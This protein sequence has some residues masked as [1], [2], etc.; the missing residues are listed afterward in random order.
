MTTI[1]HFISQGELNIKFITYIAKKITKHTDVYTSCVSFV[2][3]QYKCFTNKCF[4]KYVLR[5]NG[6]NGHASLRLP[7][8]SI[9]EG[10][11]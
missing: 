6:L 3:L 9:D 4:G 11:I 1:V 10:V 2:I 8:V 5:T 7:Y